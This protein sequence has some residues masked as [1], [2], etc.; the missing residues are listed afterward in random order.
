M[1]SVDLDFKMFI[2]SNFDSNKGTPISNSFLKS[3]DEPQPI[4]WL[5]VF[6]KFSGGSSLFVLI[7]NKDVIAL[8]L[9]LTPANGTQNVAIMDVRD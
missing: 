1:T 3:L 7:L 6:T 9:K 5:K 2:N 8:Y 4:S